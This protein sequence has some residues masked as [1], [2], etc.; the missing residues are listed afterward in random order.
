MRSSVG[1][2]LGG[3]A[4]RGLRVDRASAGRGSQ[5]RGATTQRSAARVGKP[6]RPN[7]G[8]KLPRRARR[9]AVQHRVPPWRG[10]SRPRGVECDLGAVHDLRRSRAS[11]FRAELAACDCHHRCGAAADRKHGRTGLQCAGQAGSARAADT[12]A[13]R[14]RGRAKRHRDGAESTGCAA[15]TGRPCARRECACR[16]RAGDNQHETCGRSASRAIH[17]ARRIAGRLR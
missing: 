6:A 2:G 16:C 8:R 11:S 7:A 13:I 15:R 10:L 5:P 1:P 3:V 4:A 14:E 17:V 12:C 9:H